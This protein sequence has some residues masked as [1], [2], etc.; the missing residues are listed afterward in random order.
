MTMLP[1]EMT[2][3]HFSGNRRIGTPGVVFLMDFCG[4]CRNCRQNF[5]NQCLNKRVREGK[6]PPLHA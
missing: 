2:V 5:T 1:A 4:Q 3:P 6:E